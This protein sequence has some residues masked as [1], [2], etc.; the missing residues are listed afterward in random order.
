[1]SLENN[2]KSLRKHWFKQVLY[3]HPHPREWE[4]EQQEIDRNNKNVKKERI[5]DQQ[6]EG[7]IR[8]E[9]FELAP[10]CYNDLLKGN[11]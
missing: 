7:I 6:T 1:M 5:F 9:K 2:F 4:T 10:R 3:R 11:I 8:G